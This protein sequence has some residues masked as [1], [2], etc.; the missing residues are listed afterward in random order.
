MHLCQNWLSPHS[1]NIKGLLK[2]D[3]VALFKLVVTCVNEM[4]LKFIVRFW[5][6]CELLT[7]FNHPK[8]T[9][10]LK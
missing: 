9:T 4:T 1:A 2:V 7:F 3:I 8:V 10:T 6:D 5:N